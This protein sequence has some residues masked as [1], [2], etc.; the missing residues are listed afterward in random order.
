M[1]RSMTGFGSAA[2]ATETLQ[3]SVTVRSLNHRYLDLSLHLSRRL[4]ALEPE[5]KKLVQARVQRGKVELKA[6][7]YFRG[8]DG[9]SV[10]VAGP[11]VDSLVA[12]LRGVRDRHGLAGEVA[13]SDIARFPGAFEAAEPLEE[14]V[15]PGHAEVLELA[16]GALDQLETMRSEEGRA[17]AAALSA[18]L[19]AVFRSAQRV[20]E[21]SASAKEERRAAL[22]Q[23]I[24]ELLAELSLEEARLHQ[25]IVRLVERSD[26]AEEV[27]RLCSHVEAC[28]E[29]IG[30]GSPCGKRLDF[31]AQELMREANTVG[32]KAAS[33]A[34]VHEVVA[35]KSEIERFREQVQNVE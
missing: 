11:L 32:S 3:A 14:T 17:L 34:L 21:L 20:A 9:T 22:R 19:D 35:L 23:K 25:E 18:H 2:V 26:V 5:L 27:A 24:Q 1:I 7:A 30:R 13:L 6:Q 15:T 8:E 12:A 10:R 29:A 4:S 31:L 33:T 16:K 28:R